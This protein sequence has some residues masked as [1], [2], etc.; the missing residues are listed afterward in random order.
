M[1]EQRD[2]VGIDEA[3]RTQVDL[4]GGKG[5]QL[6]ELL[7]IDGV[8]V[9]DVVCV[10]TEVFR[11]VVASVPAVGA[12]IDALSGLDPDDLDALGRRSGAVRDA[13]EAVAVPD[14]L[15]AAVTAA[16]ERL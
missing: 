5:A 16:V 14:V 9:P 12:L 4:V 7:R 3:D 6:G 2:V 13:I 15:R 8:D 10:T 1:V 11:R